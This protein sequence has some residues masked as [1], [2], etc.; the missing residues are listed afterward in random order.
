MALLE[1]TRLSISYAGANGPVTALRDI[2]LAVDKGEVLGLVGE[3]GSGKSTLAGAMMALLPAS[4]TV[5]GR[6]ALNGVDLFGLDAESRRR[7]RGNGVAA[8]FQD[9]F[10]ALDPAT[11]IGKQ[12]VAFQHHRRDL[13]RA[14]R[15]K[16]AVAMLARVGISEPARRMRQYAF[17][18]SGGIRQRVLIAAALLS[19]PELLIADEPTTAL[20]ATTEMQIV[21]L[22]RESRALVEGAIVLVS[23]DLALVAALCDRVAV[24]YAGELVEAGPARDIVTRP[25]HPYTKALLAC[26]PALIAG[27][28]RR[29]PT[30][31]GMVPDPASPRLGCAFA[32]RCA[33]ASE[34]CS[35]VPPPSL[36][37]ADGSFARCHRLA[38]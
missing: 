9:P 4:A 22:L 21:A 3:S 26:D 19:E 17:E 31:P 8:I 32:A 7:L 30:I 25:L 23:H 20:D 10:T 18:L 5:T 34:I 13:N 38:G 16:R 37:G 28:T 12:L 1:I 14:A 11:R 15:E 36:H 29:F 33:G 24:M 6:L 35:S 27:P 2:S